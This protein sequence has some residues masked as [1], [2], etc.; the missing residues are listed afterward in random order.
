MLAC[1][2]FVSLSLF[3]CQTVTVSALKSQRLV[4]HAH[5]KTAGSEPRIDFAQTSLGANLQAC[6]TSVQSWCLQRRSKEIIKLSSPSPP[7]LQ[8]QSKKE[9]RQ[10]NDRAIGAA[11]DYINYKREDATYGALRSLKSELCSCK[12]LSFIHHPSTVRVYR[13]D[14]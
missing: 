13:L 8:R 3:A 6:F 9:G 7:H 2:L 10:A 11:L 12:T 5:K 4:Q 14:R 1:C